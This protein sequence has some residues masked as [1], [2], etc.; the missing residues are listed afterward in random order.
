MF[1]NAGAYM[2]PFPA[3]RA[4]HEWMLAENGTYRIHHPRGDPFDDQY[5]LTA[6]ARRIRPEAVQ[7]DTAQAMVAVPSVSAQTDY[8]LSQQYGRR[9]AEHVSCRSNSSGNALVPYGCKLVNC[10][11]MLFLNHSNCL[12][13]R[14]LSTYALHSSA[15]SRL[16]RYPVMFHLSADLK[17]RQGRI[18]QAQRRAGACES[19]LARIWQ[20]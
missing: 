17:T 2:G 18:A 8:H 10:P 19:T 4:L 6:Y 12:I 7:L 9:C 5:A 16:E 11:D 13:A 15:V 20:G 3:I 14:N 1:P